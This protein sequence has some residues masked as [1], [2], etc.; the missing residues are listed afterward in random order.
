MHK[1][2]R[3]PRW[4]Q[5]NR[6]Q[7]P[8]FHP[9]VGKIPWSRKSH[10]TSVFLPGIFHGQRS[11]AGYSPW[12]HKESDAAEQPSTHTHTHTHT[13]TK[14]S[15]RI[16]LQSKILIINVRNKISCYYKSFPD[17]AIFWPDLNLVSISDLLSLTGG[18]FHTVFHFEFIIKTQ[19]FNNG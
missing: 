9:R 19:Q 2:L 5:C 1:S 10:S 4:R 6:H 16:K 13:H 8:K 17:S 12:D 14:T 11:Q 18:F 15:H 3:L 7:R